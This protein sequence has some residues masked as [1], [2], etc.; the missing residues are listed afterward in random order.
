MRTLG[1]IG[2]TGWISTLEYYRLI[3]QEVNR[4]LGGLEA[5]RILLH[6]F[7]YGDID[8]LNRKEDHGA[9]ASLILEAALGAAGLWRRGPSALRQHVS[10]VR[11]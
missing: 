4:R 2:G 8:R 9:I 10:P 5:A 3:N 1:L 11:R 6:S 7:N